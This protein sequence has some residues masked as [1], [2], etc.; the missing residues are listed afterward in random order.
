M[1]PQAEGLR[2]VGRRLHRSGF[3]PQ[4]E[5][6]PS[7][8]S[9]PELEQRAAGFRS[10]ASVRFSGASRSQTEDSQVRLLCPGFSGSV[11]LCAEHIQNHILSVGS[12]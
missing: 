9:G 5:P 8:P 3:S 4:V 2:P 7:D 10:G 1:P 11:C 6:V 12:C